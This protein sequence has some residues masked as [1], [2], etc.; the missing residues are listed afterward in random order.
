MVTYGCLGIWLRR[1]NLSIGMKLG[2]PD[3]AAGLK[4]VGNFFLYQATLVLLPAIFFGFWWAIAPSWPVE[5]PGGYFNFLEWRNLFVLF[6][7]MLMGI[8]ILAFVVPMVYFH[9]EMSAH[10]RRYDQE[11]D[12]IGEAILRHEAEM[13]GAGDR[14]TVERGEVRKGLLQKRYELLDAAPCWPVDSRILRRF[15]WGNVAL[16]ALPMLTKLPHMPQF[17]GETLDN[18]MQMP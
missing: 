18:L 7:V 14:A 1:R 5:G 16:F 6:F 4:V 13:A 11:A 15:T 9:R 3:G 10:R 8:E 2:H 17:I 12:E